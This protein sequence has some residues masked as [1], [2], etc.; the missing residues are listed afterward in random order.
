[1]RRFFDPHHVAM[2]RIPLRPYN[3]D[4]ADENGD[5]LLAEGVFLASRSAAQAADTD[6]GRATRR[7][8]DLRSRA[9]TT[10]HGAFAGVAPAWLTGPAATMRLGGAH[11]TV[12][13]LSPA[14][15]TAV[16][17]QLL[18]DEPGLLSAL[19]LTAASS[20]AVRGDRLEIEHPAS[21]GARFA[22]VRAT[23]VSR[24]L[25]DASRAG[26]SAAG[27]LAELLRRYP[28]ATSDQATRAML[29]MIGTGLLWTDLLPADL[30]AD[31]LKHLLDKLPVT[32]S[33]R[34]S[35]TR[36]DDLLH[37][38]DTHPPGVPQ[39]RKLLEE[40]Q[41]LADTLHYT[42]RPLAVDTLLDAEISLPPTV[43]E[44]AAEAATLLWR[45]G[46]RTGPLTDY[47]QRFCTA[48]GHHRLVPLLEVLDP[49]TGLGPPGPHDA[50][51]ADE[52]LDT[53]RTAALAA[54]LA[55]ALSDGKDE[56]LLTEQHLDQLA[57]PSPLPPPRTA[58]IHIQL[59]R[60]AGGLRI[61][62]CPGTG[63]QTAGAAPGRWTQWLPELAPREGADTGSGPMIAEI[64]CRPRTTAGALAAE[65][66]AAPWRIPLDVPARPGDLLPHDLAVTTD[67][68]HLRL[69][70]I[71]HD[72]PVIPVLYNRLAPRLLPPA[73]YVL[74][75]L[76]HAGTRPW[77]PWHWGPFS[78]W[79]YTPRVRYRHI[80][81]APA[82]WRLPDALT[83]T[84]HHRA[85]FEAHLLAWRTSACPMPPPVLVAEEADRRLP[86]DLRQADQREL[87]RR[88]I[89]RGTRTLAVPFAAPEDLAVVEGT[90]GAR[91]L[92]DLVV[93]L[94]RRRAP[95]QAAA[96][97]RRA[98]R[99]ADT[100][101]HL[102][103]SS[104]LSAALRAPGYR[105]TAVLAVLAP[106][107]TGLPD[108][109]DRW[110]WLR[111]TTPALGPHLRL[112][113]H[114]DPHTLAARIQPELARLADQMHRRG[115]LGPGALR[116]EPYEQEIE[117]YGG[118]QA[119]TAAERLFHADS[120]LALAALTQTEDVRLLTAAA[121]A[122]EIARTLAP[123]QP[124][125]ALN[126]GQLTRDQRR[127]RDAL[128]SAL[129]GNGPATLIPADLA[130]LAW[131]RWRAALVGYR[132]TVP[133]Q[134]AARCASDVIHMHANRMLALDP[135]IERIMRTLAADLLHRR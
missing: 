50:I 64:V 3:V 91:H 135:G 62:V 8:Y 48:Y 22:S 26:A 11:R 99:A 116:L 100:G 47:H 106:L 96:D 72:R 33:A 18:R 82:R 77:H 44:Q 23:E 10:P 125:S 107:L 114:A 110:F 14:W 55:D 70:S 87:L 126:P 112:R 79:P 49:V 121:S 63:S 88:S 60:D 17:D 1:M 20:A 95:H 103:G 21:A 128:R 13:T 46:H 31:P 111:Y 5:A 9:R 67:G 84:A 66:G 59:L 113:L 108:D 56:L 15:L 92:I 71:R 86:L 29:D 127:H 81:I 52:A 35:L 32:A 16:V 123:G 90:N 28:G 117:R 93:P 2:A 80:L 129:T 12:T 25:L 119:I 94:T 65:T 76:G 101:A 83:A 73:A 134:F 115:L 37:R 42:R 19:T 38:C 131:A 36:L 58:E 41:D 30:C 7:A 104:W 98:L 89:H 124:H 109:V 45:I 6:R 43:G 97:P 27:L 118:P 78:C 4:P 57:N 105:H 102:P 24:W 133:Q 39:R 75:L 69:W 53:R 130:R 61:A 132:E 68:S 54:L 85:T 120:R 51:G 122:A 74:H 40:A 34:T